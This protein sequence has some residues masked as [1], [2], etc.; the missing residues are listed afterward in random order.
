M[1]S[2]T[3]C[4]GQ[5][6]NQLAN[7]LY[8]Y[9]ELNETQQTAFLYKHF[10]DKYRSI[11]IDSE[12]KV[13][14]S[15][16]NI[17]R[18][19]L[20]EENVLC[21]KC[22]RGSNWASGY[23][24]INK[25]GSLVLIEQ[26][27]ESIRKEAERCDF[28]L[29]F[30]MLH[31]L[32]GGT[33]SGC[34]SRLAESL[35]DLYGSKKYLFTC[36]IAP[37][38][39]GELPLQHYNNLLCMSHLHDF[40]DV[41]MLFQ[42]DDI[43]QMIERL[44]FKDNEKHVANNTITNNNVSSVNN[45][46][47]DDMNSYLIKCLMSTIYPVDNVSLKNQSI[48]ME[49]LELNNILCA[50]KNLKIVEL[51]TLTERTKSYFSSKINATSSTDQLLK[52]VISFIKK[53]K[54]TSNNQN[55]MQ[56]TYSTINSIIIL[57]GNDLYQNLHLFQKSEDEIKLLL[58]SIKWNPY[59][60]DYWASRKA[61]EYDKTKNKVDNSTRKQSIQPHSS[62]TFALNRNYCVDYLEEIKRKSLIKYNSKAY[63]HWYQKYNVDESQFEHAFE[64][65]NCIIDTFNQM[66]SN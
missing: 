17:Y 58:N 60:V 53:R 9:I 66:T 30:N 35:R 64:N 23:N 39:N 28:L 26:C 21:S 15:L 8:K 56:K 48:G 12:V 14:N 62:I 4:V 13:V 43:Y 2:I 19:R 61:L 44:R 20:R 3:L 45:I 34:G 59:S 22:G 16:R 25:D 6:G 33:G 50:N 49:M 24:G 32:S 52:E 11:N 41:I 42:N 36:S 51:F 37:F 1:S 54:Q 65:M 40:S 18:T 57:R 63:L 47:L 46:T 29:S 7:Y 27:M 31:S 10:D 55:N 5:C 38:K